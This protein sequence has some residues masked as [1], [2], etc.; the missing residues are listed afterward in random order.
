MLASAGVVPDSSYDAPMSD[1]AAPASRPLFRKVGEAC[2][3]PVRIS[4]DDES[5]WTQLQALLPPGW[6]D[7][8][9]DVQI[10]P[11][12]EIAH[13]TLIED[14][15]DYVLRLDEVVLARSDLKIALHVFDAQLRGH[16]ALHSPDRIFVHAGTVGYHGRAIVVPGESFSG[17]TTLVA[18]LV[19]AGATY[20]SDEYAV[21]DAHGLV[22]PFPKPLSIRPREGL[23]IRTDVEQLGGAAGTEPLRLGLIVVSQ[24]RRDAVWQPRTLSQG[25]AVIQLLAHTIPAKARPEETM[26]AIRQAVDGSGAIALE[27]ERGDASAMVEQLFASVP[28]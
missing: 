14:G 13:F 20:Y 18:E 17:K 22:H 1:Q 24:Y 25:E 21:L 8:G 12:R 28:E 27:G 19:K 7:H 16:I 15:V 23:G 5:I 10:D 26:N 3:V 9:E 2:G 6:V 4:T 11:E